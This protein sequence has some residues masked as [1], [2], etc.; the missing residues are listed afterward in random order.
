MDRKESVEEEIKKQS[1][2]MED[3]GGQSTFAVRSSI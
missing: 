3:R 1:D 2:I